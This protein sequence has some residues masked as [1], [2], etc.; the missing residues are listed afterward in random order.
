MGQAPQFGEGEWG[1][2]GGGL[3]GCESAACVV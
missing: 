1:G 2:G 3:W